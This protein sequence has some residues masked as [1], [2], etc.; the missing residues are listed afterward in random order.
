MSPSEKKQALDLLVDAAKAKG[1]AL[2]NVNSRLLGSKVMTPK[3]KSVLWAV[4]AKGDYVCV[5]THGNLECFEISEI[6]FLE[7]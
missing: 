7:D 5:K 3:G 6:E 4:I 1:L 2:R